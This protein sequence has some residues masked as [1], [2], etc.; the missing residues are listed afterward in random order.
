MVSARHIY[1][2]LIPT[3]ELIVFI[4]VESLQFQI[5]LHLSLYIWRLA[6]HWLIV[7]FH[8]AMWILA[9]SQPLTW[10]FH[11]SNFRIETFFFPL[12]NSHFKAS[13]VLLLNTYILQ[14][15]FLRERRV[16]L[17][18]GRVVISIDKRNCCIF[19]VM[20]LWMSFIIPVTIPLYP[21]HFWKGKKTVS[22]IEFAFM[23]L[24]SA[25]CMSGISFHTFLISTLL[26]FVAVSC[27][28]NLVP[29]Q[30]LN[31]EKKS[32]HWLWLLQLVSRRFHVTIWI[33]I[34]FQLLLLLAM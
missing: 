14:Q 6:A 21:H 23:L 19:Y 28:G 3:A 32:N 26:L 29:F 20:F 8:L 13:L 11:V 5:V 4:T 7:T 9:F 33:I 16:L 34:F 2:I 30:L 31:S 22:N 18:S 10:P 27:H 17:P 25:D 1:F 15:I 24:Q 12:L